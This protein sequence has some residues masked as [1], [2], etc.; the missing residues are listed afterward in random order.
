MICYDTAL[1]SK[2]WGKKN[3]T[4]NE[5]LSLCRGLESSPFDPASLSHLI[6]YPSPPSSNLISTASPLLCG[7]A[8]HV[9]TADV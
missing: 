3:F 9:S 5:M 6:S 8:K 1:L 4:K 7:N 2:V